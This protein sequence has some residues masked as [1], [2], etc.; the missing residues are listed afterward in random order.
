MGVLGAMLLS[1]AFGVHAFGAFAFSPCPGGDK[2][3]AVRAGDTLGSIATNNQATWQ[4]LAAHNKLMN[5]NL[6]FIDQHICIPTGGAQ[7]IA[8]KAISMN[9]SPRSSL[10][11]FASTQPLSAS[12]AKGFGNVFA[13]GQCTWWADERYR[14]LHGSYVPWTSNA[15]AA[16]W[17]ARAQEFNWRVSSQPVQGS[18]IVLQ[19]GVQ[20]AWGAGHV[21]VVEQVMGNGRVIASNMNWGSAYAQVINVQFSAGPGVAFVSGY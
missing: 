18:I 16:Q 1:N 15:N 13:Y 11:S 14:Q 17:T 4:N 6:L 19:S 21:G 8:P 12:F 9:V 5:P 10:S 2:T 3:Y 7:A 20:G